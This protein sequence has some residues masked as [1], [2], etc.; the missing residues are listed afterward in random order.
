MSDQMSKKLMVLVIIYIV[1]TLLPLSYNITT[2][3][4]Y[5]KTENYNLEYSVED[6]L[7]IEAY[8]KNLNL[9][10]YQ[11]IVSSKSVNFTYN[12]SVN[13]SKSNINVINN[14]LNIS[15]RGER[16]LLETDSISC[17]S[18]P[19]NSYIYSTTSPLFLPLSKYKSG[20][21][22][23]Q[24]RCNELSVQFH[25]YRY[26]GDIPH[27][28]LG[29][30]GQMFLESGKIGNNY[31]A[32]H[33][34]VFFTISGNKGNLTRYFN[35]HFNVTCQALFGG[36]VIWNKIMEN[37]NNSDCF[38]INGCSEIKAM[39][40]TGS[41]FNQK[42]APYIL[43]GIETGAILGIACVTSL[44]LTRYNKKK[45]SVSIPLIVFIILLALILPHTYTFYVFW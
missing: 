35:K 16:Y 6:K 14:K 26:H 40:I 41:H 17:P 43:S 19:F 3:L 33:M 7:F 12:Y 37:E 28:D 45:L 29:S 21:G 9:S 15:E 23:Y 5:S 4:P 10:N 1:V 34:V 31:I 25:D 24:D 18:D 20:F 30:I 42:Y 27:M 8:S 38:H 11:D 39:S 36:S 13:V 44:L 32:T 2:E 22:C